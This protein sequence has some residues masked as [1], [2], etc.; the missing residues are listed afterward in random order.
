[1]ISRNILHFAEYLKCC[2]LTHRQR[3]CRDDRCDSRC[4]I[5]RSRTKTRFSTSTA[6][7]TFD[8]F[9]FFA[10]LSRRGVVAST[11]YHVTL[12]ILTLYSAA[13]YSRNITETNSQSGLHVPSTGIESNRFSPSPSLSHAALSINSRV[14]LLTV[15]SVRLLCAYHRTE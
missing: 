15:L 4:W 14:Q 6:L 9:A 12:T 8:Q 1:M 11:Y 7:C 2:R 5:S 10:R 3:C 13:R